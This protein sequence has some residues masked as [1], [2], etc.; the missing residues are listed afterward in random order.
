MTVPDETVVIRPGRRGW[1]RVGVAIFIVGVFLSPL[2]LLIW[3][4]SHYQRTPNQVIFLVVIGV[5]F[6][7]AAL[8]LFGFALLRGW[9]VL[10]LGSEG[11]RVG[12]LFRKSR[13]FGWSEVVEVRLYRH[14]RYRRA[15][16]VRIRMADG[17][18]V[19]LSE[20]WF[21]ELRAIAEEVAR[22]ASIDIFDWHRLHPP[23]HCQA[24]G[25]SLRGISSDKCP[26]CGACT[27]NSRR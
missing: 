16:S 18:K 10:N 27:E 4:A 9:A 26:E 11:I 15:F 14:P 13:E 6:S 21:P 19:W 1:L 25:Y 3:G 20:A 5:L 8:T 17:A 7:A 12:R 23:G 22:R 2:W 24:C